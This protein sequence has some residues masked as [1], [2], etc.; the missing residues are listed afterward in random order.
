ML[1]KLQC[2]VHTSMCLHQGPF[3]LTISCQGQ[4]ATYC[5]KLQKEINK[6]PGFDSEHHFFPKAVI[7]H[8][9]VL[10]SASLIS[11]AFVKE[12]PMIAEHPR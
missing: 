10:R 12:L 11:V 8:R 1:C 7:L 3:F 5:D 9:Q 4:S 2:L 6:R